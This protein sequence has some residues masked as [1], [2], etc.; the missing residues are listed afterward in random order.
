MVIIFN[1]IYNCILNIYFNIGFW[2]FV[3]D[4]FALILHIG[5]QRIHRRR[6]ADAN[7]DIGSTAASVRRVSVSTAAP[8]SACSARSD[9]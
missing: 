8:G 6:A 4:F 3:T 5:L 2:Y 9:A 1:S 7:V